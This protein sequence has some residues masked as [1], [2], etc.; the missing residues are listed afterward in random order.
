[1]FDG[2][3][4]PVTLDSITRLH[5]T[6]SPFLLGFETGDHFGGDVGG[7][8]F[9]CAGPSSESVSCLDEGSRD[10]FA[11][12]DVSTRVVV[13][14]ALVPTGHTLALLVI[15]L[16]GLRL[17]RGWTPR[18]VMGATPHAPAAFGRPR[19][20]TRPAPRARLQRPPAA[21]LIRLRTSLPLGLRERGQTPT[22][23]VG[24]NAFPPVTALRHARRER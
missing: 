6:L 22:K 10:A 3:G 17:S 16:A 18:T 20:I 7:S 12:F 24:C 13:E 19:A 5:F 9:S 4:L 1:M 21:I 11:L 23:T 15:G 14:R 8:F 2:V